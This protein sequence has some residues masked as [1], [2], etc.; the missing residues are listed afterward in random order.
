MA[1]VW[2]VTWCGLG[3][4]AGLGLGLGA[5]VRAR[6]RAGQGLGLVF[7]QG[8]GARLGALSAA[9][10][11]PLIRGQRRS[12]SGRQR[13]GVPGGQGRRRLGRRGRG[14]FPLRE[15]VRLVA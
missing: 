7:R 8:R 6:A 3:M 13:G 14:T 5:G 2:R 4:G 10:P 9:P 1:T 11:I 15:V 12:L